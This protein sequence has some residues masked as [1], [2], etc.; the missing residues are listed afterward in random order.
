MRSR[1][2]TIHPQLLSTCAGTTLVEL[3]VGSAV[4]MMLLGGLFTTFS[5]VQRL[6]EDVD[7]RSAAL[8]SARLALVWIQNDLMVSGVGLQLSPVF[9]TTIPRDDGGIDIRYNPGG[10][11]AFLTKDGDNNVRVNSVVGF[12][13]GQ[14]VAVYD[15]FGSIDLADINKISM[16]DS[17]K[18]KFKENLDKE[19]KV[20]DGAAVVRVEEISYWVEDVDGVPTLMRK[21]GTD[22]ARPIAEDID[23]FSITYYENSE[24]PEAFDPE[25]PEEQARIRVIEVELTFPTEAPAYASDAYPGDANPSE[26]IAGDANASNNRSI[27][28]RTRVTPRS[29]LIR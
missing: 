18:I 29:L 23:S 19:Y 14:R 2:I 27:V 11:I 25:T 12:A 24:P 16:G 3:L 13:P 10:S 5:S 21:E 22:P 26:A 1:T 8:Q 7:D 28:L 9:P 15:A 6:Y 4:S 20:A 17:P